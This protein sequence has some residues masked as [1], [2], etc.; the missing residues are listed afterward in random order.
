MCVRDCKKWIDSHSDA[1]VYSQFFIVEL[2]Q[3]TSG[4][5]KTVHTD[6]CCWTYIQKALTHTHIPSRMTN[7]EEEILTRRKKL[8]T[9]AK[10]TVNAKLIFPLAWLLY[11]SSIY[12]QRITITCVVAIVV[13][14]PCLFEKFCDVLLLFCYFVYIYHWL[15]LTKSPF[16]YRQHVLR[17]QWLEFLWMLLEVA[18]TEQI[19]GEW[20]IDE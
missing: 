17:A 7:N 15:R 9:I 6:N 20:I 14:W 19:K 4:M 5:K 2:H 12:K 13:I 1:L 10:Y 8:L 16:L 11:F 3:M 18:A